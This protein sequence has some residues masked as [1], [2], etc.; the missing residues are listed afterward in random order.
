M[1]ITPLDIKKQEFGVKFRGYSPEEVHSYLD[2]IALE[3]EEALRKN[4]ELEQK[5]SG[6]Q[7]RLNSYGRMETILQETL[8]TT[9]RAA[10]ET[11]TTAEKKA[12]A[13]LN[14]ARLAAQRLTAETNEKLVKIQKEISDLAH[15]RDSFRVNF[16]S[17]LESQASLLDMMEKRADGKSEEFAPIKKKADLSDAE[18]E[19]IVD[20]F[21]RKLAADRDVYR[22]GGL[23][24]GG[25]NG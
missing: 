6:M 20:E 11:R 21:E 9:Q 25:R 24:S 15:Q 19:E 16:R 17:L 10:E 2:M 5:V 13:T 18:L 22:R 7:E 12:E 4:L 14:E 1:K 3:L 23:A 8:L